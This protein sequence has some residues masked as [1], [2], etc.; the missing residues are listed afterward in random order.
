MSSSTGNQHICEFSAIN[1]GQLQFLVVAPI[2]TGAFMT[3][4]ALRPAAMPRNKEKEWAVEC[5]MTKTQGLGYFNIEIDI[6]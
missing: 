5:P 1:S 6:N 4:I 3:G 2:A